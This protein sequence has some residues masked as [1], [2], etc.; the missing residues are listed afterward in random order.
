MEIKTQG[1]VIGQIKYTGSRVIL[2][3]LTREK[4]LLSFITR[5]GGRSR[6][7]ALAQ[8]CTLVELDFAYHEKNEIHSIKQI[9][10]L[11]VLPNLKEDILKSTVSIFIAEI[12][13]RSLHKDY[14]NRELFDNIR[15]LLN[16]LDKS[17]RVAMYP[18]WAVLILCFD[19]GLEIAI[20]E[21]K[22]KQL[23]DPVEGG[24]ISV[25]GSYSELD[26][27]A[28]EALKKMLIEF[29]SEET[30]EVP[31]PA[32]RKK[33]LSLLL[34]YIRERLEIRSSFRSHEV[35]EVILHH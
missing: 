23:F 14:V 17:N 11:D 7:R 27:E 20:P 30:S 12:L 24:F 32:V 26:I 21:G 8:V 19:L 5:V 1:L 35:L 22:N 18:I 33:V 13:F 29:S 16:G 3:I 34:E 28:S 10:L 6:P 9:Q 31:P 4:G 15:V 2:H 25:K